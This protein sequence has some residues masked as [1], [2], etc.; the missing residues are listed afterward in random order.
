MNDS[1]TIIPF[2]S[3]PTL[4]MADAPVSGNLDA[5][6]ERA[7]N[8]EID[9]IVV[10]LPGSDSQLCEVMA[11]L[12]V[13]PL[14]V[15]YCPEL[16]QLPINVRGIESL[17]DLQLLVVQNQP[18]SDRARILKGAMD[19]TLTLVALVLL[20]PLFLA[21]AI[22]IKLDSPGPVF[23]RQ[24]RDGYNGSVIR[25]LKFRTMTVT[26]D[27]PVIRQAVPDDPRI[28][29]VGRFLRRTS[30][31][32]LPQLFTVLSGEMSLVGPR[33]HAVAHG[34]E[35]ARLLDQY[36]LR[37]RMK[38]GLTGWAQVNGYRGAT[39][40]PELMRKRVEHDIYYIENW[41]IWLDIEILI[42]T[43]LVVLRGHNAY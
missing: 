33:P 36:V 23:F 4:R 32:E 38:P 7:R 15:L 40:D 17:G 10:A 19:Y 25:V 34:R 29:R 14:S 3:M 9:K 43:V 30:L 6:L 39:E 37:H 35:Y 16:K 13:L 20:A 24:R 31:D 27:G 8:G 18:L 1:S 22:A 26:E 42:R 11:R 21:I 28:T 12:A 41:S 2:G 5:L